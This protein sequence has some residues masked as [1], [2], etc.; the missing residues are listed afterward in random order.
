MSTKYNFK[1]IEEKW[2]KIWEENP[3]NPPDDSK[4]KYYCLDMFPY[5][6]GNGLHVGHWRGYV[7]SDVISRQKLMEGYELLHPMGW[8]AFGLPAENYA[9]KTGTHPS[10]A[11]KK[12]ISNIKRQVND[13]AAIYDW[14]KE[15]NTTDPEYYKWTQWIFIQ[16][17]KNGLAYEKEMPLNWCPN[18]KAV[19]ANEEATNGVCDRCGATVTKKNLRQWMLKITKYADRL[20]N[21]LDKLDW[22]E[23]VKKMQSD[24]IGKSY[25]AEID[26]PVDGTDKSIKVY[27]TRP[28]TLY[29]AT[30]MVLSPEHPIVKDITTAEYKDAMDKYCYEASTKSNVSRMTDKEKTGVFTGS[31]GINPLNG[32]KTPIW[33]SDYVLADYGTGAIMCVPAHDDRDFEFAKKFDLPIIQVISKDGKEVENLTE[34]YTEPGI[35]IN[36]N[37]FNGMKSEDAKKKVPDYMEEKG[38]GKKTVNFKLRDWVFSRQRYWGEPI[39]LIHCEKCGTVPVPEDQLPVILPNVKSYKPTDTGES[40]LAAIDEWVNTTCPCCGGPAKRETNTMPQWAGSSWYYL[41]YCDNHNDKELASKEALKKW[42]PVDMYVGGV[43]HAVLHLL[44]AR[45]YT[46]FLHDIGVVDFDEPFK[47]L[48]NQGM[49][50]KDG[51]KMSKNKGNVVS[52]DETVENYGCDSLRMY[53][54]FIGPPELDSEWDDNGIDGVFRY[55][56]KVWKFV[57][58]Y[59]DKLVEK[60]TA[61]M[62]FVKNKLTCEITKRLEA[63]TLNT[64]VSGFMEYTNKMIAVAKAAGGIDKDSLETLTLLLAPFTPHISEEMWQLLGHDTSVFTHGWPKYDESKLKEETVNIAVQ[65]NGKVKVQLSVDPNA[66]KDTVLAAAK[67][68]LGDKLSGNIVK[69]IY[70]P[71]RIVNIVVK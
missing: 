29:G 53:E 52:P 34:A 20:L 1:E 61:E 64:V 41:R 69:E 25:G 19:L 26:F 67:A 54:L 7:L 17:F 68:A 40:P 6:S 65:I 49:I 37:E 10:E 33:V 42:L 32:A 13:I 8:D 16:M 59:K 24:W 21:D 50:T 55:L 51:A 71:G 57:N 11:T 62:E 39:P 5:P 63:L 12:S 18:C 9:I 2:R 58:E 47:R 14:D 43:E 3:V 66:D 38:F 56:N 70:V 15:I 30:F 36:S 35:M 60:P 45:F 46:K 44:Y 31:Y 48:F 28:D 23:K 27:T 22:P 4:P